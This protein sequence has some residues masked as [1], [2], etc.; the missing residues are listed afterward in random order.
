MCLLELDLLESVL[1]TRILFKILE[2]HPLNNVL[3]IFGG[4]VHMYVYNSSYCKKPCT[5]SHG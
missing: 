4:Y 5:Y 1:Y 2:D 3:Y